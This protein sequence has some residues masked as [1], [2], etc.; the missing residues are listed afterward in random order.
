MARKEPIRAVK[1]MRD[2]L[3][4]ESALWEHI[5]DV[6]RQVFRS[7]AYQEIRTPLVEPTELFARGVGTDTDIVTKEMY[8]WEDWSRPRSKPADFSRASEMM[9]RGGAGQSLTLR[10]EATAS[11][12]RAYIEH[13][14]YNKPGL[15]RLFYI[16]PMFRRERPQKGRYRQFYQIG[17][18]AIGQDSPLIDAEMISMTVKLLDELKVTGSSLLLNSVGCKECR[19]T[20]LETLRKELAKVRN[21]LCADCQRRS[22]TNP[23]RV[24][25]CKVPADQPII[26]R[27]PTIGNSLCATCQSHFSDLQQS[28][29]VFGIDYVLQPR[30]VRGLDY[31][32][33]T[34]FEVVH[35]NLGA[36][37]S[38]LGGGRYDGL[39]E[40]LGGPPI[41]GVGFSIGEDRLAL[42][43]SQLDQLRRRPLLYIFWMGE[44]F[45]P[46]YTHASVLAMELRNELPTVKFH[47]ESVKPAKAAERASRLAE[48]YD[49][50]VLVIGDQEVE[51]EIYQLKAINQQIPAGP[52]TK[53]DLI[54]FLRKK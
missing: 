44:R 15:D 17:A 8:T 51:R 23:L 9:T 30:L 34:T 50:Y 6:A 20:Y 47:H 19:P 12:I 13:S 38:L 32:T 29:K 18:E 11:V 21:E 46:A 4:P 1:G 54:N 25:D 41:P 33:R 39:S 24:L 36:Q 53:N 27:L 2:I 31:Y 3:P 7:Y 28:L 49:V 16:G 43:V 37:N 48:D 22:E 5:E 14:L 42:V 45:G 10:P 52:M 40:E 26:D 35:G